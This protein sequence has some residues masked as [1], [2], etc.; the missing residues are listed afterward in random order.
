M[1]LSNV[2]GT[3]IYTW[4]GKPAVGTVAAGAEILV[5]NV[6][7]GGYSRWRSDGTYWRPTGGVLLLYCQG[8]A[9]TAADN[10]AEQVLFTTTL[11]AGLVSV[12]GA[13]LRIIGGCDKSATSNT[14]TMRSRIG[15]AGASPDYVVMALSL[16]TTNLTQGYM[17]ILERVASTTVQLIGAGTSTT[18]LKIGANNANARSA[19]AG[20]ADMDSL[21]N[22]ISFSTQMDA[23]GGA[24][25]TIHGVTVELLM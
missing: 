13:K 16:A 6:G 9:V 19:A 3:A 22:I 23:S 8:S 1:P 20:V 21:A 15:S 14:C 24:V 25:P 11:P 4:A 5:S 10:T 17:T 18:I 2:S 12:P 7:A